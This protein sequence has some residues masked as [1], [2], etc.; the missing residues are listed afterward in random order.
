VLFRHQSCS[1]YCRWLLLLLLLLQV[2]ENMLSCRN[3][4]KGLMVVNSPLRALQ[5][6]AASHC[7]SQRLVE[8]QLRT[9]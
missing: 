5:Q 9:T 2:T 6:F 1:S 3:S 4:F 7:P 8:N